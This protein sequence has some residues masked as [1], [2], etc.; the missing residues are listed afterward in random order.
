VIVGSEPKE[1]R[2]RVLADLSAGGLDYL[3]SLMD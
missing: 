1:L 3:S 2:V